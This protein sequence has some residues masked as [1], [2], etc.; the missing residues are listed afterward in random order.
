MIS[1][2]QWLATAGK[3]HPP[4]SITV[5]RGFPGERWQFVTFSLEIDAATPS[6][7]FRGFTLLTI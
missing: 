1:R 4:D 6:P 3:L 2:T 7:R 5:K